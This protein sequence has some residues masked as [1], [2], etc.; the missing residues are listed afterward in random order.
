MRPSLVFSALAAALFFPTPLLAGT[1]P[2]GL[3]GVWALSHADCR[4]DVAGQFDRDE[5]DRV[6]ATS[7]RMIGFCN[8]GM[9]LLFQ[10]HRCVFKAASARSGTV[11]IQAD[12]RFRYARSSGRFIIHRT[13]PD[14]MAFH[15]NTLAVENGIRQDSYVRCSTSYV[16]AEELDP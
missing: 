10:P 14:T 6:I 13:G 5:I 2:N 4:R 11:T 1:A 3:R 12:C 8:D 7:Y 16:C 15:P 9:E